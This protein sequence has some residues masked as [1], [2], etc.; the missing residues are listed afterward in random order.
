MFIR[1]MF[2]NIQRMNVH[3]HEFCLLDSKCLVN[4]HTVFINIHSWGG[5]QLKNEKCGIS[6]HAV[7]VLV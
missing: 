6:D 5:Y 2:V 3:E 7:E 4:I 1:A